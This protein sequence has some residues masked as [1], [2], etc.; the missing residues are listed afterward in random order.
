L[1]FHVQG[2]SP[3]TGV[4]GLHWDEVKPVIE[5]H[6]GNLTKTTVYVYETYVP[7]QAAEH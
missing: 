5:E 3:P 1:A 6:L 7:E 2:F 4:G